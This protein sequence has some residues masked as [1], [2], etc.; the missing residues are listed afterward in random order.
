[1]TLSAAHPYTER[2]SNLINSLREEILALERDIP[3]LE[4][5]VTKAQ[6]AL[7]GVLEKAERV[8]GLL[9]LY[10][11]DEKSKRPSD[12]IS[13]SLSE[14]SI[15]TDGV[16]PNA[17][18]SVY[19]RANPDL[20]PLTPGVLAKGVLTWGPSSGNET[21]KD[22]MVREISALLGLR[23]TAHRT[24]ILEYLAG[25]GIDLGKS[26]LPT[27]AAFLSDHRHLFESDGKGN[28][29]IR[30]ANQAPP[31][32]EIDPESENHMVGDP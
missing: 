7:R 31:E 11:A 24:E 4:V 22:A 25:K 16:I 23:G 1:L 30:S 28:F 29:S 8:R 3:R 32:N 5:G 13:L 21:K 12:Q 19:R 9:A 6:A 18:I 14:G 15:G 10:E 26:P 20:H 2:M 27:L 17:L